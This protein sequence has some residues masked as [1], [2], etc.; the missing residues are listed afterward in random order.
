[1][2]DPAVLLSRRIFLSRSSLA[3]AGITLASCDNGLFGLDPDES[4]SQ[5]TDGQR[6]MLSEVA[7]IMIPQTDTPGAL[8]SNTIAYLEG[9]MRDWASRDT[10]GV[11]GRFPA[12][13]D[14][15]S[16]DS[17]DG[18]FMALDRP[19]REAS[20]DSIDEAAFAK[21]APAWADDYRKVKALIFEIHYTS[22]EANA[23]FVLIPGEFRGD[24]SEDEYNAL[25][26]ERKYQ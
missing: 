20:L 14:R 4:L 3:L 9:L 8:A 7:D 18:K 16:K 22:A 13:M 26:A 1:M 21:P 12:L 25:I 17:G 24:I 2:T 11:F 19:A 15:L 6:A 10:K 5:F 23:D